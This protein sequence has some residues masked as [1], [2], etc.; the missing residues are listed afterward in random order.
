MG[1]RRLQCAIFGAAVVAVL[2]VAILA[3]G[4]LTFSPVKDEIHFWPTARYF[5]QAPLSDFETWR[6]YDDL[7]TPLPFAVWGVLERGFGGGIAVGRW[8]NL[9]LALAVLAGVAL[10]RSE[11]VSRPLLASLG[12]AMCPYFLG[13]AMVLYTDPFAVGLV[14]LGVALHW[15]G[16]GWLAGAVFALAVAARQTMVAFPAALLADALLRRLRGEPIRSGEWLPSLFAIASLAGWW[17]FFAGPAPPPALARQPEFAGA[18]FE[19]WPEHGLYALACLGAYYAL[20]EW[21]LLRRDWNPLKAAKAAFTRPDSGALLLVALLAGA[22][23]SFPPLQNEQYGIPTMG[24]VDRALRFFLS[25]G[26]RVLCFY[27]L[28]VTAALRFRRAGRVQLLVLAN[29]GVLSLA[30]IAWDKYALPLLAVLWFLTARDGVPSVG[31]TRSPA[32]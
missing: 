27:L 11:G 14:T 28:A 3:Q 22:F 24:F 2:A 1:V 5:S 31:G 17:V 20:P 6:G 26:L 16:R 30:H 9:F 12:L 25:D 23:L 18:G 4:G 15:K 29:L 7:N 13:T 10:A 21:L 8:L 19:L 32:K